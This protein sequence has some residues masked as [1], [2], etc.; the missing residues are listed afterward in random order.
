MDK[1]VNKVGSSTE[2]LST[3][4][5]KSTKEIG[6]SGEGMKGKL[7]E[8]ADGTEQKMLGL[9]DTVDG[10]AG[11]FQG[12]KDGSV[13]EVA[14]GLADMA[15]GIASFVIP[16]IA[17][18]SGGFGAAATAVKG[19]SI[20]LLT[21][22]ITWIVLGI[23]ALIAIIV[24]MITHWD[25][26]K[27]I[28]GVVTHAI[29]VAWQWVEGIVG[30][31]FSR[32]GSVAESAFNGIG[33]GLKGALNFVIGLLNHGIDAINVLINGANSALGWTGFHLGDI[34]HIPKLHTGGIVPGTVG[35][36]MLAVLQAGEQVVPAGGVQ[37]GNGV[38]LHI[39]GDA[40][41]ALATMIM[42][43]YRSNKIQ[44]VDGNGKRVKVG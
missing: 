25:K 39:T 40:D 4:V 8:A 7:S 14:Q 2:K 23:I 22:P 41:S 6:E 3:E 34:P 43:L 29:V 17:G 15:G 37:S 20:S 27:A 26:V 42:S 21:S 19:F 13:S 1:A 44:V 32:I 12:F 24:L 33:N 31:V 30:G 16:A 38:G 10:L 9:H 18:M 28:V 36:E 5:G 35:S 11:T